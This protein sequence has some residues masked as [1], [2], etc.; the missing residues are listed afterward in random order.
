MAGEEGGGKVHQIVKNLISGICPIAGKL[1]RVACLW[2][3]LVPSLFNLVDM[4]VAGR[5][6][7]VLCLCTVAHHENL[8]ILKQSVSC[9]E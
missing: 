5:V 2:L 8:D 7:V 1:E 9:P 6:A 3:V 4:A